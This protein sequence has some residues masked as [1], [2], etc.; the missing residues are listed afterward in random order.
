MFDHMLKESKA[1]ER[2]SIYELVNSKTADGRDFYAYLAII[3]TK[4]ELYKIASSSGKP[5]KFTDYGE[6]ILTGWG[7]EPTEEIAKDMEFLFYMNRN[8]EAEMVNF[9][10]KIKAQSEQVSSQK[11]NK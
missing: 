11:D 3:P 4:Y 1:D 2:L 10:Q 5:I 6:I 7:K 8:F 9:A